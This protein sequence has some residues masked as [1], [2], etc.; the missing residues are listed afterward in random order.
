ME[1]SASEFFAVRRICQM[2]ERLFTFALLPLRFYLELPLRHT[3][4]FGRRAR[5]SSM[6]I[7]E[8]DSQVLPCGNPFLCLFLEVTPR[9]IRRV[10]HLLMMVDL[11]FIYQMALVF[12]RKNQFIFP[13]GAFTRYQAK[14]KKK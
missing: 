3:C 10:L 1:L 13:E 12:H 4:L 2:E 7:G 6:G 9:Q 8:R 11:I 14:K 5:L